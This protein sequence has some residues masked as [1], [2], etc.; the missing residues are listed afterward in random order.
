MLSLRLLATGKALPP[1]EITSEMLDKRLHKKIGY[2]YKKSGVRTRFFSAKNQLQSELGAMA[3]HDAIKNAKIAS[4]SIDLIISAC[5]VQEQPLPSTACAIAKQAEL[6]EGTPAFDI[7]ASCLSFLVALNTAATLLNAGV[8]RR[9]AIV[10]AD[11]PSRGLDWDIPESS[12]IFG[13]G[14]AAAII[15]KGNHA[16]GIQSFLF[17]TYVAGREFCEIRG[18]GT[19]CNPLTGAVDKDY[20]FSMNGQ[21]VL[22]MA[23]QKMPNF[24]KELMVSSGSS[25]KDIDIMV[26]H[27]ASH[28]GMASVVRRIGFDEERVINIY[29]THGN[30]VAASMPTALH[31]AFITGRLYPGKRAL[32][33][34]S[35]AGLSLGGMLLDV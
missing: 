16:Q 6:C 3:L 9:I 29:E 20:L 7:N 32:L 22:K 17:K 12:L 21:Q 18:G 15:E 35:A 1:I 33:L 30:Q 2:T 28:L 11:Q 5:G 23:L 25:M 19:R 10:S 14:A 24:V 27:Q 4:N 34:G 26:P 13:D 8:Y 31:E